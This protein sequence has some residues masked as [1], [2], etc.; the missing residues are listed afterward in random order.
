M[1]ERVKAQPAT[2]L[3]DGVCNARAKVGAEVIGVV[4][5]EAADGRN[6]S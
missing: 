1:H 6:M 4:Q 2:S 3:G 5:G